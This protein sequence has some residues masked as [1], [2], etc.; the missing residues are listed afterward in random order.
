MEIFKVISL[1]FLAIR[2][3]DYFDKSS[4]SEKP[5]DN[6]SNHLLSFALFTYSY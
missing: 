4:K 1:L 6:T 2:F 3:E 5:L